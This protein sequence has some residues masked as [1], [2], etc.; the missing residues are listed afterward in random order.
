MDSDP[1]QRMARAEQSRTQQGS[2]RPFPQP[3]RS[4]FIPLGKEDKKFLEPKG[5][6]P[7]CPMHPKQPVLTVQAHPDWQNTLLTPQHT[8][9]PRPSM[10]QAGRGKTAQVTVS[11]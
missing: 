7:A 1:R 2:H 11:E 5:N 9:R 8:Q 6:F 3:H 4:V 10:D